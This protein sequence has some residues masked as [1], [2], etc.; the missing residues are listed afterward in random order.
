MYSEKRLPWSFGKGGCLSESSELE[1][2]PYSLEIFWENSW[3]L[4]DYVWFDTY[5]FPVLA[6]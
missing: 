6:S 1:P 2:E 3:L 5:D 4:G